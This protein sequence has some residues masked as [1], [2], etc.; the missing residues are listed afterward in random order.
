MGNHQ[1]RSLW[2]RLT[3]GMAI[4]ALIL[5]GILVGFAGPDP[6]AA[7][8]HEICLS[9]ADGS[10]IQPGE[11]PSQHDGKIHCPWCVA[12]GPQIVAPMRASV[13]IFFLAD[14]DNAAWP[15]NDQNEAKSLPTSGH[16]SRAPPIAA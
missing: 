4:Y 3:A 8:G 1:H 6:T 13:P 10:T 9:N 14:A 11:Q 7:P 16:R 12:G 5:Q 2:R 15:A